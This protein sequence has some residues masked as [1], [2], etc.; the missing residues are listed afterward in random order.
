MVLLNRPLTG[1]GVCTGQRWDPPHLT[2]ELPPR[3]LIRRGTLEEFG[4]WGLGLRVC[5]L[6]IGVWGLKIKGLGFGVWVLGFG[7]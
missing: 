4:V 6:G 5:G 3:S 7:V 2:P 1:A